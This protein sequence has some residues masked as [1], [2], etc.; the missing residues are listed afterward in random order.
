MGQKESGHT[1][2]SLESLLPEISSGDTSSSRQYPVQ[3]RAQKNLAWHLGYLWFT[4]TA[5]AL[6]ALVHKVITS[7]ATSGETARSRDPLT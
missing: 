4:H 2:I 1:S 6:D 5:V 3:E 7:V